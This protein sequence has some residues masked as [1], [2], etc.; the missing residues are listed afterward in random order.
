[1]DYGPGKDSSRAEIVDSF[2]TWA[3]PLGNKVGLWMDLN[4]ADWEKKPPASFTDEWIANIAR[5]GGNDGR[6]G[7]GDAAADARVMISSS[8]QLGLAEGEGEG[9]GERGLAGST[10]GPPEPAGACAPS[11]GE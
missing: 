4:W 10:E 7:S 11:Y 5:L 9:E 8:D 3:W 2:A 1:M 6:A